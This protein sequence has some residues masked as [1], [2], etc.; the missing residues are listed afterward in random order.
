MLFLSI[1]HEIMRANTV[2]II[3][4]HAQ[5]A[6]RTRAK[7]ISSENPGSANTGRKAKRRANFD[8]GGFLKQE[9]SSGETTADEEKTA[10]FANKIGVF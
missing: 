7:S 6:S 1:A 8:L 5:N 9:K 10:D 2:E 4:A 3:R